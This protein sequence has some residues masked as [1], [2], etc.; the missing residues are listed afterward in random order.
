M[1]YVGNRVSNKFIT[2]I[3]LSSKKNNNNLRCY[4]CGEIGCRLLE[5]KKSI[6]KR[7]LLVNLSDLEEKKTM[8]KR[9]NYLEKSELH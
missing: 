2:N 3:N 4:G 8:T 5:C 7:V 9:R 6:G 1:N